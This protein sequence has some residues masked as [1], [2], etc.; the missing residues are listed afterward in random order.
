M[1]FLCTIKCEFL[2]LNISKGVFQ[3]KHF[4]GRLFNLLAIVSIYSSEIG[5]IS[6]H[7]GEYS[8]INPFVFSFVPR[9]H[10]DQGA[11]K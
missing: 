8:H 1:F 5:V 10:G 9:C 11:A 4:L 3:F 6:V 2:L 7:F